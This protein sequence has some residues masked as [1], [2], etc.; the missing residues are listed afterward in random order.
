MSKT[1]NNDGQISTASVKIDGV[2]TANTDVQI[3][4]V[5]IG[6]GP[7]T[8]SVKKEI[9]EIGSFERLRQKLLQL[10]RWMA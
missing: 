3:A 9:N 10:S 5:S 6:A 4:S 1:A 8:E 2:K 7:V